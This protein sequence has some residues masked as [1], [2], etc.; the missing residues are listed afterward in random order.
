MNNQTLHTHLINL[1]NGNQDSFNW[2][3][4]KYHGLIYHYILKFIQLDALAEEATADVF[5]KLWEKKN[6]INPDQAVVALLYKIAKDTAYN[7]LKKI[8]SNEK[9]K[10][11]YL[12]IYPSIEFKSG[13]LL[14]LE[15]EQLV[16]IQAIIETLPPKRLAIFKMRYYEGLDNSA[17]AK[18]LEISIN[19]VREHLAKARFYLK[20]RLPTHTKAYTG[21]VLVL[22]YMV[23]S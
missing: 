7:Y 3:Y 8:A 5:I 18:K 19:T 13:E 21:L 20:E 11:E 9:L 17:I 15:K 23:L 1:K 2:I 22:I 4:D 14:F 16:A 10:A 6:I 12:K